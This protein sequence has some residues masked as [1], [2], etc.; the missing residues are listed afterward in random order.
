MSSQTVLEAQTAALLRRLALEQ[1]LQTRRVRDEAADQARDIE[2]RARGEARARVHQAVLETR[3]DHALAE[4]RH[5]A[6]IDTRQRRVRQATLRRLLD[7]AWQQLPAALEQRWNGDVERAAWCRAAC[8]QAAGRLL[9]AERT[10]VELDPRWQETLRNIVTATLETHGRST[11]EFVPVSGLGAG[12]RVRSGHACLDA[13]VAGL[14][15]ARERIAAGLL[16]EFERQ[17]ATQAAGVTS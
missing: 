5:L 8:V 15:A 6:A 14:L 12:I 9:H 2:R 16:A 3:R 4:A 7:E 11:P 13:T 17:L 10:V 1:D